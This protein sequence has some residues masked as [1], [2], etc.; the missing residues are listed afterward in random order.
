MKLHFAAASPFVRKVMACAIELGLDDR[1][2]RLPAKAHPIDRDRQIVADNPLGQVPTFFTDDGTALYDSRVICEYLDDLAGGHRLFPAPGA[3]RW[4]AL[5]EQSLGDGL[6]DAALLARYEGLLRPPPLQFAPWR[7]G[8][9]DKIRCALDRMEQNAGGAAARV[10]IGTITT[11][12]AL[13]YLDFRFADYDWRAPRPALARWFETFAGR[14]AM[15]RT[16]PTA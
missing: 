10:D 15:A 1:I 14:P 12:C 11:G 9:M 4:R 3:A 8:Q 13:G 2:E 7:D 5:V 16:V 6:L